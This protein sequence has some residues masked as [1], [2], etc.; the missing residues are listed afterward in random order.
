MTKHFNIFR[1][2]I[3]MH[4]RMQFLF[5]I[6][7]SHIRA[8]VLAVWKMGVFAYWHRAESSTSLAPAKWHPMTNED[9]IVHCHKLFGE[10]FWRMKN[11]RGA[12]IAKSDSGFSTKDE[13]LMDAARRFPG[14]SHMAPWY[15]RFTQIYA[16]EVADLDA[17]SQREFFHDGRIYD[18]R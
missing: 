9:K 16:D 7:W 17:A 1:S 18:Y 4:F 5:L 13:C 14:C 6:R 10:W 2:L 11:D 8:G 12:A 3:R 15:L